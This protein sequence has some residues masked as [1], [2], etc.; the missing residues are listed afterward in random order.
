MK[1]DYEKSK[2]LFL[3]YLKK[4]NY[5]EKTLKRYSWNM[6]VFFEWLECSGRSNDLRDI[7]SDDFFEFRKYIWKAEKEGKKRFSPATVKGFLSFLFALFSFLCRHEYILYNPLE[8]IDISLKTVKKDRAILSQEEMIKFLDG[9]ELKDEIKIRDRAIFELMYGTGLRVGEVNQLDIL[10]VDL[11][12]GVLRVKE[13]K[14]KKERIVPMGDKLV[15]ILKIYLNK[16][17][18]KMIRKRKGRDTEKAFFLGSKGY[19]RYSVS[20]IEKSLD[21]C[22]AESGLKKKISPHGIRHSVATHLLENGAGIKYVK[23]L[24]GHVSIQ[25]T[26]IYTHLSVSGLK[27]I[28]K[29]YHPRENELYHESEELEA[30]VKMLQEK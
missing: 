17:R 15:K 9:I 26:V 5:S 11:A 30:I 28:M 19:R 10:D 23:E 7:L 29:Q 2:L 27:K 22:F 14:G 13:G 24:L 8:G 4:R 6:R 1:I 21:R 18:K 25:T 20:G 16:S 12:K 3:R